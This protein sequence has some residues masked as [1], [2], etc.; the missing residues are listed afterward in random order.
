LL[1][2]LQIRDF[3]IID[4]LSVSFGPGLSVITGETGAGK[5]ILVNAI[6]LLL[7]SRGSADLIRS[8]SR[9]A[10]VA[11]LF[12]LPE[13]IDPGNA[14]R[15]QENLGGPELLVER[16]LAKTGRNRA[17]INGQLATV[18][19]LTDLCKGMVSIS[20]QH[21]HQLLLE[22][23]THLDIIDFFGDLET[24]RDAY[25]RTFAELKRLQTELRRLR[26]RARER[27]EKD[28]LRRFQLEE[29]VNAR[30]DMDE[31]IHLGE[32]RERLR[33]AETLHQ[34]ATLAHRLL[35]EDSGSVLEKVSQCR[36][37]LADLGRLDNTLGTLAETL[38]S[39]GHQVA[40][41][42]LTLR[43]YSQNIQADPTR[44]QWIEE[45]LHTLARLMRKYGGSTRE[46]ISQGNRLR[47]EL[48][49]ANNDELEIA[50][51]AEDLELVRQKALA[52]AL[53]LSKAR[54]HMADGLSR[55]V[56]K[57]LSALD[58]PH[59]RFL[60][61]FDQGKIRDLE[62]VQVG[63]YLLD[64]K[65]ID[66]LA[67]FFSAN[68][69]E[70]PRPM[71]NIASGGELSRIVLALKELLAREGVYETL[72]F[73]EVDAGI[74]G[75]TAD[76][77]GQRLKALSSRHQ[78]LCITHLPQIACH[79]DRHYV[80]GKTTRGGRTIAAMKELDEELRME[81]VARMLGGKKI[82]A[83]TRAH[84]REML[85]QAKRLGDSDQES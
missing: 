76:R 30:I 85:A 52:E 5:S 27:Q 65:G 49:S 9:E 24:K 39:L 78:V 32:E 14:P 31:E 82:S 64:E 8:G 75:S 26:R 71:A 7:G 6:N 70:D 48:E 40:D 66:H 3:A 35:Y 84:A 11:A 57:R 53:E 42:S 12:T 46:V 59:C 23:D 56:E 63:E 4:E 47:Q 13:K 20:G 60:P 18:R 55:A 77:V 69:G 17:Y 2:E 72:I 61:S 44:L 79:G 19:A 15:I 41:V 62:S 51:M 25:T 1:T 10:T 83:K 74:G 21:E 67:F 29:I 37:I 16:T 36:K 43:D 22:P 34:G 45:R 58:M 73:D 68:P 80:V 81:E 28:E 54:R 33:Y 50:A 38:E